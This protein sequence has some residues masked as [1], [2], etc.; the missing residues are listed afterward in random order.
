MF[1]VGVTGGIASGKSTVCALF[2]QFGIDIIDA[3]VIAKQLVEPDEPCFLKIIQHFGNHFLLD[4]GELN[5]QKLRQLIFE[6]PTA[7]LQLEAILHPV[8]RQT[9]IAQSK[10]STSPYCILSIPLLIE[11]NMI[12]LVDRVLLADISPEKQLERVCQRDAIS[13]AQATAIIKTQSSPLERKSIADDIIN[14]DFSP[15][16]LHTLVSSFHKKYL[17]IANQMSIGC[18]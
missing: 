8:I 7:K 14:N 15:E 4:N 5:R 10:A 6:N 3:D 2:Q 17:A 18:Q 12:D 9:L 16:K 1:R 11:A 13:L